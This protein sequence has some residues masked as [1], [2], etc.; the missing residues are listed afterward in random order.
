MDVTKHM[1]LTMA[2]LA[3][4]LLAS[5]TADR[6]WSVDQLQVKWAINT[7]DIFTGITFGAGHQ[8]CQTVWDIDGDGVNEIVFGTRRGNS[9]RLWCFDAHANFEWIYPPMDRDGLSGDPMSKV[10]LIDL[11]NDDQY[12]LC[13]LDTAGRLHVLDGAGHLNWYWDNPNIGAYM[14]GP[15][16][17]YDVDGDGY[18][19][20]FVADSAGHV[21][22][23]SH[24]GET[25]WS[26]PVTDRHRAIESQPTIADIDRDGAYELLVTS[27]DRC[28]Y[29]LAAENG[30]EKWRFNASSNIQSPVIVADTNSDN[31]YEALVWNDI[32]S[33]FC[34]SFWGAQIWNFTL[35][36][37]PRIRFVQPIGD[38]N[39]DGS[40]DM[41]FVSSAGVDV[42]NIGKSPPETIWQAN[43]TKWCE[44]GL[45]PA[46]VLATDWSNYPIIADFDGDGKLDILWML[47]FPV[48]TDAATGTVKAY[49]LNEHINVGM[50]AE[51]GGWWGDVEGDGISEW[52]CEVN[53]KSHPKTQIYCLTMEGR[54]PARSS[55]PEYHHCAYP[56]QYQQRQDWLSLKSAHSNSLWFPIPELFCSVFIGA[57]LCV[58]PILPGP[59]EDAGK[60]EEPGSAQTYH[61]PIGKGVSPDMSILGRNTKKEPELGY[62]SE[63]G[64]PQVWRRV[65]GKELKE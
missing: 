62:M 44:Q 45:V 4:C 53:G 64:L 2:F 50:R 21:H 15:P 8:G 41:A 1:S 11:N 32:G 42:I 3:G 22:R 10:S 18:V 5:M 27:V 46:G 23:L 48:V 60:R 14:R 37:K 17:A 38:V 56:A 28:T 57:L 13:F 51:N 24:E 9:R 29:C 39:G 16:Q 59:S 26:S 35:P 49:Y 31:E 54:F 7:S 43:V 63:G 25:V 33:L 30:I 34:L 36:G 61:K 47:P 12:E 58:A 65:G 19:E 40:M 6:A 52:I 20:F 55:W